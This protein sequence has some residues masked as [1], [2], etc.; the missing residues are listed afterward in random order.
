MSVAA[1]AL[2]TLDEVKEFYDMT[3]SKQADDDLIEDLIDRMTVTFQTYC[4]VVSFKAA[5]YTEY[6]DGESTKYIFPKNTPIISSFP[7]LSLTVF[8]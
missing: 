2:A 8:I 3:G 6:I 4:G 1:N 5:D 7:L